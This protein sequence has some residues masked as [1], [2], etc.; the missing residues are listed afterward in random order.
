[1]WFYEW[2][3][4]NHTA[5]TH[6]RSLEFFHKNSQDIDSEFLMSDNTLVNVSFQNSHFPIGSTLLCLYMSEGSFVPPCY[7]LYECFYEHIKT[8][9]R[10][11][12]LTLTP[13]L[14]HPFCFPFPY[15]YCLNIEIQKHLSLPKKVIYHH[16]VKIL[17]SD[18]L[19]C[20]EV[21]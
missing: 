4:F 3:D 10:S 20:E 12:T 7:N 18:N 13:T 21:Y 2:W 11:I 17:I 19:R 16:Y 9:E 6:L 15:L 14:P 5:H 1:M 8:L